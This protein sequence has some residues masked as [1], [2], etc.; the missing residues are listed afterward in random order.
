VIRIL[1]AG[2]GT[3]GHLMPALALADALRSVAPEV[4]PVLVG[5]ERG[6]E[7]TILPSRPYRY[8]LLP[9]EPIYRRAW[10]RNARWPLLIP[11]LWTAARGVVQRESPGL[12]VGTGGYAAGPLL[13]AAHVAGLPIALQEQNALPGITTRWLSSRARQ[14]HLGFPEAAERLH[15]GPRTEVC[16]LGNPIVPPV[17]GDRAAA[18]GSLGL[19]PVAPV[20]LVTGGSQGSRAINLAVAEAIQRGWPGE[21]CVLWGTGAGMFDTFHHYHRPPE[22]QVRPFWDPM[23]QA[24]AAADLV[25]ARAGAMTLAELAAW[26]LPSVLI[27]LPTAAGDH[28]TANARALDAAGAALHLPES[29][30]SPQALVGTVAQLL[31]DRPR[32]ARMARAASERGRPDAARLIARRLLE[33]VTGPR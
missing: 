18:R 4:E 15:P 30:L 21:G 16:A 12:V 13:L 7:T 11:R 25:I 31:A 17:Q 8:H 26:G 22:I 29:Q 20:T 24:Y 5:A 6:V 14:I 10:W 9:S 32:L 2:G 3:G 23:A 27:P 33:L 1:L 19:G 28:Q